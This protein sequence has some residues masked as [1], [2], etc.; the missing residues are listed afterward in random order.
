M[1]IQ[2]RAV[3]EVAELSVRIRRERDAEQ[4]D[5][6]RVVVLA[7]EGRET[8]EIQI[9]TGRSRGFVQR[10][11]YAYR[12]GGLEA[13]AVR[14]RGGS[15]PKFSREEQKRFI[16][17]FKAGPTKSDGGVCRLGG[18]DAMRILQ[19]EFGVAYTLTGV[20]E[21]LHRN[22][23]SCLRPRPR[24]RKGDPQAQRQW[25]DGAP[26]LCRRSAKNTQTRKSRSGSRTKPDSGSKGH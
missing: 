1:H 21:L 4:R 17:R 25:L 13:L 7:I 14:P 22:G 5:R 2:E 15:E 8:S 10:W 11:A 12:D 9:Q 6:Y 23:L 3:G 20:Y 18:R 16:E 19:E 24:H 26:L